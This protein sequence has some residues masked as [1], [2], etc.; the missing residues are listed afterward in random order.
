MNIHTAQLHINN[1]QLLIYSLSFLQFVQ[2]GGATVLGLGF[3]MH[4]DR[5][6]SLYI[7]LLHSAPTSGLLI[8]FE[9]LPS[10]FVFI[11]GLVAVLSFLGCCGACA[12]SACFLSV[13]SQ[14]GVI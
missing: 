3:Y 2:L 11:G 12:D 1:R 13:V 7:D 14:G 4:V 6:S 10:V 5:Q 8:L 9:K